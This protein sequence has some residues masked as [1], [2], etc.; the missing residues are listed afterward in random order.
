M[1]DTR[2]G[3]R[4]TGPPPWAVL[5][6]FGAL[7]VAGLLWA[8]WA[9]YW[10]KLPSVAGSHSLGPS[11]LTGGASATPGV[12]LS[13]GLRFAGTYFLAIW[14]ALVVG[15]VL[16]A[17]VQT[18]LPSAWV[19]RLLG[20][21]VRGGVRASALALPSLM[22]S[23][24]AAPLAVGLR[25][26][27]ADLTATLAYWLANPALNPVVLA[28]CAFV[29]PWPWTVLRA[30]AGVAVVAAAVALGRWWARRSPE[31]VVDA[32]DVVPGEEAGTDDRPLVVRFLRALGGVTVRLLPEYLLLVVALGAFRGVLFPLSS[33]LVSGTGLV[34][35]VVGVVVLAVAGTLLPI[36]TGAEV[37]VVAAL[38]AVGVAGPLAAPLLITLPALSLPSLLMVRSAFPRPLLAAVTG[39]VAGVGVLT[40]VVALAVGL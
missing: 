17:A 14:P 24:C 30:A 2:V 4:R 34:L 15:L 39:A 28:F 31:A 6:G 40:S 35:L 19:T 8:K 5:L 33:T 10:T 25:R 3:T 13:A 37:A 20:S 16:A 21:G 27:A 1:A 38:L 29:L 12:S 26:R 9:P 22:C 36:P 7:V 11:I 23:C 32:A 18:A